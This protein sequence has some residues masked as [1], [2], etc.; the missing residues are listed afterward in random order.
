MASLPVVQCCEEVA[1]SE[2]AAADGGGGVDDKGANRRSEASR[3]KCNARVKV[4]VTERSTVR[5]RQAA[6]DRGG[7][8]AERCADG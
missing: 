3:V 4:K 8:E 2:F 6:L 7:G 5:R 1:Q